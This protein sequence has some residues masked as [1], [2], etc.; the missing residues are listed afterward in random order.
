MVAVPA[1]TTHS[2]VGFITMLKE[3]GRWDEVRAD[4]LARDPFASH[5]IDRV[6]DGSWCPLDRGAQLIT[7]AHRLVGDGGVRSMGI[8][9]FSRAMDT[10]VLAPMLRSWARTVAPETETLVKLAP[11]L[12]RASSQGLGELKVLLVESGHARLHFTSDHPT[13]LA[14]RPWH[15][16]LEGFTLALI[17]LS[18]RTDELPEAG[19]VAEMKVIDG[20]L[21]LELRWS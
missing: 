9:R 2:I 8:A 7:A 5:W 21:E 15:V 18:R 20:R 1:V 10:G 4:V 6:A 16:F 19:D 14:C 11:H 3:R 13:F 12:W 17:G